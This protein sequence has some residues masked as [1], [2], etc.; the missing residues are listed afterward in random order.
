M[1]PHYWLWPF[2]AVSWSWNK[3][4][5]PL[6]WWSQ[7]GLHAMPQSMLWWVLSSPIE[8]IS[9]HWHTYSYTSSKVPSHGKL[10]SVKPMFGQKSSLW[11][12]LFFEMDFQLHL[13]N[14][15]NMPILLD[16]LNAL[17]INISMVYLQTS[18]NN[19][20]TLSFWVWAQSSDLPHD[21]YQ[22]QVLTLH[23]QKLYPFRNIK[24]KVSRGKDSLKHL[25]TSI[26]YQFSQGTGFSQGVD[27]ETSNNEM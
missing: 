18:I 20:M 14:A 12:P 26:N 16:S 13:K 3:H 27:Q 23:R 17:I 25:H 19:M 4:P 24:L 22:L 21:H 5:Y 1:Y 7:S 6:P 11:T 15:L 10:W 8:M 2:K 9:N